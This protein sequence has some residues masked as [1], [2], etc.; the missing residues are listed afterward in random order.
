M[1]S[2]SSGEKPFWRAATWRLAHSR[3]TSHSHGPGSVSSK[4]LMSNIM[5][6]SGVANS[7]KLLTWASPH[8]W[9]RKPVAGVLAR[10]SAITAAAP[11]KK[12]NGEEAMRP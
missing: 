1:R 4:S 10:S 9:T 2:H 7:P 12:A 8:A 5:L 11:R 3:F 6:R